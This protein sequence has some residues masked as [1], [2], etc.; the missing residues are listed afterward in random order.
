MLKT[1]GRSGRHDVVE[2][3]KEWIYKKGSNCTIVSTKWYVI[4]E[5]VHQSSYFSSKNLTND[6]GGIVGNAKFRVKISSF[7]GNWVTRDG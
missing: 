1:L 7:T 2:L 5:E 4:V 6:S 3:I